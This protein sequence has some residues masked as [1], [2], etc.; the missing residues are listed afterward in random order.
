MARHIDP[1]SSALQPDSHHVD[2]KTVTDVPGTIQRSLVSAKPVESLIPRV[3]AM[4][5]ATGLMGQA[6]LRALIGDVDVQKVH[7]IA[8]RLGSASTKQLLSLPDSP[9]RHPRVEIHPGDLSEPNLGLDETTLTHIFSTANVIIHNG[10]DTSHMKSFSSIHKT[11]FDSTR[12]PISM[13][14]SKNVGRMIPFHY[15]STG[16]VWV[17]SGLDVADEVSAAAYPPDEKL[18]T[19]YSASKW[20]SEMFLERLFEYS[21]SLW[22]I[23]IHRPA[24]VQPDNDDDD[25]A[26]KTILTSAAESSAIPH[27]DLTDTLLH[28]CRLMRCVPVSP[29]LRGSLNQVSLSR[30]VQDM[31]TALRTGPTGLGKLQY[32]HEIGDVD[33]P[34]HQLSTVVPN[35]VEVEPLEWARR[36]AAAGLDTFLVDLFVKRQ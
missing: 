35:A 3:V 1:S 24:S 32:I 36:A 5:G 30:V 31:M 15:V 25:V 12:E 2:W 17:S 7:C 18:A 28:Y 10:A 29:G 22:P 19:G 33:I 23:C 11:N 6:Y 14:L 20:A 4:I 9:L 34:L 21:G 16:S 8:V 26:N 13:C 27:L